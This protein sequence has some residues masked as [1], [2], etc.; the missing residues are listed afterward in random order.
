MKTN[1]MNCAQIRCDEI[2]AEMRSM[3]NP[4]NIAGMARFGI[5]VGNAYGL[6]M[7]WLRAKA[8]TIG[9][10]HRL[11][12][13]LWNTGIH[14]ARIL[15]ALV[16]EPA[17]VTEKQMERWVKEFDSWDICDQVCGNLFDKTPF[18][19]KKVI[20]WTAREEEYVK[21]AGYVLMAALAVHDKKAGDETFIKF[22]PI[23]A[24]GSDDS[25]NFVMKAVNWAL[26][27]IGKRN[28]ALNRHALACA[29]KIRAA[30]SKPARWI[31]SG[32]IRELTDEKILARVKAKK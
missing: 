18:A 24:A 15:A 4:A 5:N 23:I 21:R 14:E 3:K 17:G 32:A 13:D 8:K 26:R 27:Q 20:E 22:L 29:E 31:A 12:L 1:N 16:D 30:G 28:M 2:I 19:Y 10:N 11:A 25:R 6:P 9:K 7:P